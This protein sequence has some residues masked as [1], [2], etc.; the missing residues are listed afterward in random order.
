MSEN[1]IDF[2]SFLANFEVLHSEEIPNWFTLFRALRAVNDSDGCEW[3]SEKDD[4]PKALSEDCKTY[5][6]LIGVWGWEPGGSNATFDLGDGYGWQYE[7]RGPVIRSVWQQESFTARFSRRKGPETHERE[8]VC[9]TLT[10][11]WST[12]DSNYLATVK[13]CG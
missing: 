3:L 8:F 6:L 4:V 2:P 7:S 10:M 12:G 11:R 9:F 13:P 5:R 1:D